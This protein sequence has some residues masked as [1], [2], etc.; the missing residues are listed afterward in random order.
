[1]KRILLNLS[2]KYIIKYCVHAPK[3]ACTIRGVLKIFCLIFVGDGPATGGL[4][5]ALQSQKAV[6]AYCTRK[7]IMSFAFAGQYIDHI[8]LSM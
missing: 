5:T 7:Q 6:S 1:M 8:H 4:Y 2:V 3:H